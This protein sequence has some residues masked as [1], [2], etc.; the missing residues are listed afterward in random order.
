MVWSNTAGV[1]I[2]ADHSGFI[3]NA[4]APPVVNGM[5]P[6]SEKDRRVCCG[7]CL[8]D[9]SLTFAVAGA[10]NAEAVWNQ[11]CLTKGLHPKTGAGGGGS[12]GAGEVMRGGG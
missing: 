12:G 3:V 6:P 7:T 10:G 5:A 11:Q 4:K 9:V 8:R 2:G 1:L